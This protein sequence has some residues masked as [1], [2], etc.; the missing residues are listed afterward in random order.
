VRVIFAGGGGPIDSVPLDERFARWTARGTVLYWPFASGAPPEESMRWFES[1][2]GPLGV[3]NVEMWSSL[4]ALGHADLGTYSGIYIGGGNTFALLERVRRAGAAERLADF[5]LQGGVIYGGSAGAI[6]LGRDIGTAAHA[7]P[8]D[9]GLLDT[10][11]LDMALGYA[12][13][14]HYRPGDPPLVRAWSRAAG[15][16]V[17]AL[18]ERTGIVRES[19]HLEIVGFD[20]VV[21]IDGERTREVRVGE[22]VTG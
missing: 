18:S 1:T 6:L 7:D 2:Y 3:L 15:H 20:P 5:V 13:W 21:V 14:C 19:D 17:L 11:G 12:I 22:R 16:P 9:V 4:D 10:T 8:N